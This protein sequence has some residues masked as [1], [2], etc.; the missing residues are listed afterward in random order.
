MILNEA[1]SFRD[2]RYLISA[3]IGERMP[4]R[5]ADGNRP[6]ANLPPDLRPISYDVELSFLDYPVKTLLDAGTVLVRLDFPVSFALFMNVWWMRKAVLETIL[7]GA[8]PGSAALRRE[9]QHATALPKAAKG[10]RT[11][12]VEIILTGQVY[13]WVGKASPLFNKRGGAEQIYLPNLAK[14][15]GPNR[16]DFAR[17]H[18]TCTLPA[19]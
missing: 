9:W 2:V 12:I 19:I 13:A 4:A 10:T 3:R 5:D 14:G 7:H 1:Y 17:L 18:T 16:S 8:D 6:P 11:R 15:A